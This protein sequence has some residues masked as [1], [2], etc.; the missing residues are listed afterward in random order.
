MRARRR[1][2]P[3]ESC[4]NRSEKQAYSRRRPIAARRRRWERDAEYEISARSL[5]AKPRIFA[6]HRRGS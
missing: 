3:P 5:Y 4:G 6:A 1:H 2:R